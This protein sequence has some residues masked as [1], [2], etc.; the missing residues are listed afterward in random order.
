V[1]LQLGEQK[2]TVS[3]SNAMLGESQVELD[4]KT[5][6][7]ANKI[8]LNHKYLMDGLN[9][10]NSTAVEFSMNDESSPC[11]LRPMETLDGE[12]PVAKEGYLYIIMPI[13]Q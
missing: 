12:N 2:I 1:N 7:V 8:I 9:N 11:I 3:A 10:L 13:K 6:G 4:V 5:E